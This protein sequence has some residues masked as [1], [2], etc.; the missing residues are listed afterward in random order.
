VPRDMLAMIH[1]G[2]KII[3][4]AQN[5]PGAGGQTISITVHVNG[6]SNAPDVRRAAGQGAREAMAALE[7]FRRFA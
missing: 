4:A 3:P 1:Q 7:S 5:V 6:N 2:E